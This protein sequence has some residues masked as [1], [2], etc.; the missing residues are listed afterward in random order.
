MELR[1][2]N[3]ASF[4]F[5]HEY[6]VEQG[7]DWHATWP[8]TYLEE[9]VPQ[10]RPTNETSRKL[11]DLGFYFRESERGFNLFAQVVEDGGTFLTERK[12]N[13]NQVL[14]FFVSAPNPSWNQY[15][16][17]GEK[18]AGLAIY[19]N[20]NGLKSSGADA[21]LYLHNDIPN[22]A[23][24]AKDPGALVR[25]SNHVY[26]A[27]KR[28][29]TQPADA[30]WEDL[31]IHVNFTNLEQRVV[32]NRGSLSV[33]ETTLAGAT[34]SILDIYENVIWS[35]TFDAGSTEKQRTFD[36]THLPEGLY[37]WQLNF[38]RSAPNGS[39]FS[40][41]IWKYRA[42]MCQPHM[43]SCQIRAIKAKAQSR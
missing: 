19:S 12:K 36:I 11:E 23:A 8:S 33:A 9:E 21:T 39:I 27:L 7:H 6:F 24:G 17:G 1:V 15:T 25:K 35:Y 29:N 42:K 13:S 37:S 30:D 34:V 31:G 40:V 3:I 20:I 10:V 5:R 22:S 4:E 32:I 41:A 2:E 16:K 18:A 43:K 28:T 26:E 38:C 14:C